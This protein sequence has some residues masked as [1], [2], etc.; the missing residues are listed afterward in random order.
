MKEN[1]FQIKKSVLLDIA[2]CLFFAVA[3]NADWMSNPFLWWGVIV[4]VFFTQF[5]LY[6]GKICFGITKYKLWW[7]SFLIICVVSAI[8]SIN[9]NDSVA[10]IKTLIILAIMMVY[11]ESELKDIDSIHRIMKLYVIGI[12]ITLCYVLITQDMN[13][14]QLAQ[15]GEGNTGRW[16]GNDIGMNAAVIVTMSIYLLPKTKKVLMKIC[17]LLIDLVSLY[18]IYWMGSRK[19]IIFLILAICGI[20]LLK[21]P[22][23]LIRNILIVLC[24]VAISWNAVLEIPALYQNIGWR[25]EALMASVTGKG[26]VDSSTLL[27]EKYIEVGIESFKESPVIGYGINTYREINQVKTGHRTYSHN[28][29]IEIAVGLGIVG[30][31]SYYWLY[32]YLIVG[33]IKNFIRKEST[34]L[35]NVLFILFG[36]YLSM[37][38][39]L[40]SYEG[41]TQW[42]L[43]LLLYKALC[44]NRQK[45]LG[46]YLIRNMI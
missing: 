29:F 21:K 18:L 19:T 16:N 22:R 43:L 34:F 8:Y 1:K 36:L 3:T 13:Q 37:Q 25:L 9:R 39:G 6:R 2:F 32:V 46:N 11:V 20:I 42:M 44:L 10:M 27:R 31:I 35:I 23:K 14:F 24:I 45:N 26:A 41:I 4:L 38:V 28:N 12:G 5:L 17:Y 30:I 15:I 40:V 33:Y 7:G